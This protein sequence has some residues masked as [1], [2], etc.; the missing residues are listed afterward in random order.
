VW[1]CFV[2]IFLHIVL[3]LLLERVTD[4]CSVVNS[5]SSSASGGTSYST[6]S[7]SNTYGLNSAAN[8]NSL[9]LSNTTSNRCCCVLT[10][11]VSISFNAIVHLFCLLAVS[12]ALS[13]SSQTSAIK[14]KLQNVR[15]VW[16][17]ERLSFTSRMTRGQKIVALASKTIVIGLGVGHDAL[18]STPATHL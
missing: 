18:A 14:T 1:T 15:D 12:C 13:W 10:V 3:Y 8:A 16:H 2:R 4:Y 17:P 9:A 11:L 5:L 7:L 6:K